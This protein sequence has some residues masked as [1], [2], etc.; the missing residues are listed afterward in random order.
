MRFLATV[1]AALVLAAVQLA[2]GAARAQVVSLNGV[3]DVTDTRWAGEVQWED[4]QAKQWTLHFRRD[5]VVVYGYD[6]RTFENGR[7]TQNGLLLTFDTNDHFA[8]YVGHL[9][10]AARE[11]EGFMMNRNGDMG[12][13]VFLRR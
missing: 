11:V 9:D 3:G 2:P 13:F 5:G 1:L 8:V 4:D 12:V 10:Q 6:G 7:W